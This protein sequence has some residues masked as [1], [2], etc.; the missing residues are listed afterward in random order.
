MDKNK[1]EI[2]SLIDDFVKILAVSFTVNGVYLFG[3]HAVAVAGD[4]SDID[5]CVVLGE[6]VTAGKK[7]S[8]FSLAQSISPLIETMV[9]NEQEYFL[10]SS[11]IICEVK[12]KGV[13]VA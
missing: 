11:D 4:E 5:L 13:R 3:S 12:D 6:E 2:F 8:I 1:E 9:V 10:N 7:L